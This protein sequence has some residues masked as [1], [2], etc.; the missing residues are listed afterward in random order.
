MHPSSHPLLLIRAGSQRQQSKQSP[1]LHLPSHLLYVIQGDPEALQGHARDPISPA[2]PWSTSSSSSGRTWLQRL[3]EEVPRRHHGQTDVQTTST[4]S[5]WR[6]EVVALLL[7]PPLW[8]NFS[9]Q[10]KRR[11]QSPFEES[12]FP[13]LR[14]CVGLWSRV[15]ALVVLYPTAEGGYWDM[16]INSYN[17]LDIMVYFWTYFWLWTCISSV[18]AGYQVADV[19][20]LMNQLHL[21]NYL[22]KK[23]QW[24]HQEGNTT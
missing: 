14:K 4:G 1:D 9:P 7:L 10:L 21:A 11:D 6:G 15:E 23:K 22:E 17:K 8:L 24:K 20:L 18:A 16:R 13:P 2:C 19:K 12:S 3:T 5:F